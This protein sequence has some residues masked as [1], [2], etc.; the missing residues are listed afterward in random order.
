MKQLL[1]IVV[2]VVAL[3]CSANKKITAEPIAADY[4]KD[5]EMVTNKGTI[6]LRL[7][8]ETPQHRNNFIKLVKQK[9]YDSVLFHRVIQKFMIQG[10]DP[11][12]KRAKPNEALGEGDLGYTVPAE[13]KPQLFHKKGALAAARDNNPSKASS[14][15]QFYIVQGIVF[16]NETIAE[17]KSRNRW[18]ASVT[19]E[20][21]QVYRTLG[22]TPHLD[23]NYTVFGEVVKGLAVV[24]S[25]AAVPKNS[26]NRPVEDIKIIKM[27]LINRIKN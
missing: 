11:T 4:I 9:F 1:F 5:I 24:D 27:R 10:G 17:A 15:T 8:D 19:P 13:F 12:S 6:I 23:Q 14:A 26:N 25:I 3:A 21:E 22:G 7:Y 18:S 2:T 20:Q 16:N